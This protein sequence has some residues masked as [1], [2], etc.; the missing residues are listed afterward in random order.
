VSQSREVTEQEL[1]SWGEKFGRDLRAPVVITLTGDLGAG[2]TTL[3]QAICRGYGV[4]GEVTSPTF[5][6][7]HVYEA[8]RTP[9][10]H[11]D[12]YRL[13]GPRDL[14]NIGWDDVMRSGGVV[15]VEWPER[16]A[17]VLP[18]DAT[19][20]EL[21]FVKGDSARRILIEHAPAGVAA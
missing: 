14:Q 5:A 12:L 18:R 6:I 19:A 17:S 11:V 20:I 2:K 16:A 21:R 1:V 7:V 15:I 8:P 9:V 3:T 4:T 13:D 10:H